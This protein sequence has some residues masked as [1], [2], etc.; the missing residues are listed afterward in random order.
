ME[1][2]QPGHLA[3]A[4]LIYVLYL[5]QQLENVLKSP[6]RNAVITFESLIR[7]VFG[8]EFQWTENTIIQKKNMGCCWLLFTIYLFYSNICYYLIKLYMKTH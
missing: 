6:L 2:H 3:P 1:K 7:E 8:W 4:L 5:R